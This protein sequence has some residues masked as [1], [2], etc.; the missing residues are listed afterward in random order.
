MDKEKLNWRSFTDLRAAILKKWDPMLKG[1]PPAFVVIDHKGVVR[2]N[3]VG[4]PSGK[5]IEAA[6][7][8]IHDTLDKL[9][10]EAEADGKKTPK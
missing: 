6:Q 7:K 9:I 3:W 8:A 4:F 2:N 1:A 10:K 5:G